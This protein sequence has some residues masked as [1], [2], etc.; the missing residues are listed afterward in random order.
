V[1]AV[2]VVAGVVAVVAS[3]SGGDSGGSAV[4]TAYETAP[5]TVSGTV[6][7]P[8]PSDASGLL[9]PAADPAVG[10]TIPTLTGQSF[11]GSPVTVGETGRPSIVLF[12]AHWC[13]HCQKEVPLL[14]QWR[15]DGSLPAGVDW[16]TVS[17][18]VEPDAPNYPPSAWLARV[19]WPGPVM[20]DSTD[21]TAAQAY[22][23]QSF[24]Y[25][26]AVKADGT[27]AA[28]GIGELTLDQV[29]ELIATTGVTA[30]SAP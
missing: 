3:R 10:Q 18:S 1:A 11:D 12:V 6:L 27:V 5:V 23:L 14:Q 21:L 30:T 7:P 2:V 19:G 16:L 9:D 13:P 29:R 4:A 26:V 25:L 22:G 24:P 28:R 20:A 8:F 15:A 17:T